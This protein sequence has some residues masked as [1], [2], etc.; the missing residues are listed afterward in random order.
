MVE[1]ECGDAIPSSFSD[2]SKNAQYQKTTS[3]GLAQAINCQ[4]SKREV[5][6]WDLM[7][8]L[9][10]FHRRRNPRDRVENS[11]QSSE[12]EKLTM[13]GQLRIRA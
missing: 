12:E 7:S 6:R 10:Q 5:P 13:K 11:I 8:L 1:E 2:L 3:E 9:S 4:S